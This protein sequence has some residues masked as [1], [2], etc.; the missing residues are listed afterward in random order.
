[1][2]FSFI[3]PLAWSQFKGKHYLSKPRKGQQTDWKRQEN[4][5]ASEHPLQQQKKQEGTTK[6]GWSF[7]I[8]A[9]LN[10]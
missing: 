5:Q 9:S 4:K 6:T 2:F 1:M 7:W 10:F 3:A 8:D